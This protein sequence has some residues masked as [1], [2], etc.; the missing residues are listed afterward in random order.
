MTSFADRT[1]LITG[2]ASGIGRQLALT[3][4]AEGAR[5]G[6]LDCNAAGLAELTAHL[7]KGV[8]GAGADVTDL[9]GMQRAVADLEERLGPTDVL[10]ACAGIAREMP[11]ET[12]RA[13]DFA[14]QV[15]VNLIGVSNSVD[16]VL[17]GMRQR[18]RGHLVVLSSLAS[19]HGLPRMAGYCASKAGVNALFDALRVELRPYDIAVTTLCPGFIRTPMTAPHARPGLDMMELEDAVRQMVRAIRARRPFLAFPSSAAWQMRLL[20]YLPLS[21]GDWLVARMLRRLKK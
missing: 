8:A 11:A 20:R 16:A 12:Y 17:P 5:I 15:N 13:E 18:R 9:A 6:A 19:Y 2:A 1:V 14:A 3:F 10:I 21:W 4:A 7:G